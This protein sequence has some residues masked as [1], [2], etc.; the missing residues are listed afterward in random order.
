MKL[1]EIKTMADVRTWIKQ[2]E[3]REC[4]ITMVSGSKGKGM[5]SSVVNIFGDEIF[6]E[7]GYILG[8][9]TQERPKAP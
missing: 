9:I 4:L 5:T 1:N 2:S 3:A 7:T 8:S 6:I